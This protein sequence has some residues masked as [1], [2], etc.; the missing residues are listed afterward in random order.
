M[1]GLR[2]GGREG[3]REGRKERSTAVASSVGEADRGK[4]ES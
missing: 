4:R 1:E 2:E 3:G